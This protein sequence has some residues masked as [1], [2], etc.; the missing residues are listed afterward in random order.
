VPITS[1]DLKLKLSIKTGSAGNSQAQGDPNA[2]LG[3]YISTTE[4][5]DATLDNL[6]DDVSGDE[7]AAGTV[8][9]RCLFVHNA[10][11]SLTLQSPKVWLSGKRCAAAASTDKFT[12][13]SHGFS[14]G[15]AV[16]VEAEYSYDTLPAGVNNSTTYYVVSST[17][18]DF[19][20]SATQGGSAIDITADGTATVRR[21]ANCTIA[22]AIDN[23][24]A[25]A[26]GS[27]SAQADSVA[28]ETTAPSAVGS[29]SSPTTK[30]TGLSL[31]N[32]PAGQCRAVWVRRTPLNVGARAVD[33]T[34][35]RVEGDTA[36]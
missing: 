7:N 6:F 14:D 2:S 16:R 32:L 3:K 33:G 20:L 5:T 24:A 12:F 9:Y 29:F 36:A 13:N 31:G 18:N 26:I 23:A 8:E 21:F 27:A 10:H 19:K 17:T 1:S 25:S 15:E 4:I 22:L 28:N 35:P 34:L 30:A 11:A